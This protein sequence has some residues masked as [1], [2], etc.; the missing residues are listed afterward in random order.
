MRGYGGDGANRQ[1]WIR[2]GHRFGRRADFHNWNYQHDQYHRDDRSSKYR[3]HEHD[4]ERCR[5]DAG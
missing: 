2:R 5:S 1:R 3:H 4:N